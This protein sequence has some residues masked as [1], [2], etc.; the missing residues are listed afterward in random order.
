[1]ARR[2]R[3]SNVLIPW[4]VVLVVGVLAYKY[5][6]AAPADSQVASA[7]PAD[8][9][10][11]ALQAQLASPAKA[12]TEPSGKSARD[13]EL[14]TAKGRSIESAQANRGAAVSDPT[15]VKSP[16]VGSGDPTARIEAGRRARQS[17]DLVK[18]RTLLNA[19]LPDTTDEPSRKRLIEDLEVLAEETLFSPVRP[20]D[21]PL[22]SAHVVR[23]G[24][25][26]E[27]IAKQYRVTVGLLARINHVPDVNQILAGQTL[28]VVHGPFH[29]TVDKSDFELYVYLSDVLVKRFRAGLGESGSTPSGEWRVKNKLINPTYYPPR[30]G[31]VVSADNPENPL[32]ERWIGLEGVSGGAIGQQKYGIH[33]TIEPDSVGKNASMG[34]VRLLNADVEFLY[35]LLVVNGSQVIVRD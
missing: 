25:S 18:A 14:Q 4:V 11:V 2:R 5:W 33:G 21:D 35:D 17:G 19:A 32:G 12:K 6:W 22:V 10:G 24:E 23:S 26:L 3:S 16:P 34:C 1:M 8:E 7:P 29:A 15:L 31:P 9:I 27:R 20:Q 28:K 30:G 13:I